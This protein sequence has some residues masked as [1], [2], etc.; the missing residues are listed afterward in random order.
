MVKIKHKSNVLELSKVS[1][2]DLRGGLAIPGPLELHSC[3]NI[4]AVSHLVKDHTLSIK[5][6]GLSS[7]DESADALSGTFVLGPAFAVDKMPGLVCFRM[8]FSSSK[9]SL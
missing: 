4:H 3:H 1:N 9:V 5:P 6:L 8:K 7:A 2:S